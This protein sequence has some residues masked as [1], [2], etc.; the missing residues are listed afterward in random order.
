MSSALRCQSGVSNPFTS[1]SSSLVVMGDQEIY[2]GRADMIAVHFDPD[3]NLTLPF[4]DLFRPD[5]PIQFHGV[6]RF[7]R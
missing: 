7:A 2:L 6:L 1:T 3:R 4:L 5:S